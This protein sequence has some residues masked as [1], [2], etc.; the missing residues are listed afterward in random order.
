V[1][2][3]TLATSVTFDALDEGFTGEVGDGETVT[4]A[5]ARTV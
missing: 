2:A 4:V 5:V 3:E 1:A